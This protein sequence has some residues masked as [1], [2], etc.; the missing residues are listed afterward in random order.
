MLCHSDRWKSILTAHRGEKQNSKGETEMIA[1]Q[2]I[3]IDMHFVIESI[4]RRVARLQW[5]RQ[6]N[7]VVEM[8]P[9][10]EAAA[11]SAAATM[12]RLYR[13]VKSGM[14][15]GLSTADRSLLICSNSLPRTKPVTEK[16][17]PNLILKNA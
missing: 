17:V 4:L 8:V 10:H 7:Q 12:L 15:H 6:C 3:R 2:Q 1:Q 9:A 11:G 16:V 14:L 13:A 5:C